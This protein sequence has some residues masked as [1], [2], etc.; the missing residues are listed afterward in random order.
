MT[1]YL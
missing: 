1:F